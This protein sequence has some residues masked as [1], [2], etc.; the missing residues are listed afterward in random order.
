MEAAFAY[1]RAV[2]TAATDTAALAA[3]L[4]EAALRHRGR[5]E[6]AG[7]HVPS[8]VGWVMARVAAQERAA[9]PVYGAAAGLGKPGQAATDA[10][11]EATAGER[12]VGIEALPD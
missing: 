4:T 1:A 5:A 12:A 8:L 2:G 7:Y 3:R 6:V 9:R 10:T 11:G